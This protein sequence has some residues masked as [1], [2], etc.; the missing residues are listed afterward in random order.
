MMTTRRSHSIDDPIPTD[1]SEA[2]SDVEPFG[3]DSCL[4]DLHIFWAKQQQK[5]FAE[6]LKGGQEAFFQHVQAA[7]RYG[8][9]ELHC[10]LRVLLP[11]P[12]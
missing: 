8:G 10:E 12:S 9:F 11:A 3:L 5:P 1:G 7:I 6:L 4:N 2:R